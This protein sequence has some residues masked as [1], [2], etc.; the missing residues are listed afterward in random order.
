V[1]ALAH[2]FADRRRTLW[3]LAA[4]VL[5]LRLQTLAVELYNGD[6]ANYAGHALV[7]LDGGVPYVDF[8]EKKPPLIYGLYWASFRALGISLRM[9]HAVTV[10][11][12]FGTCLA[13]YALVGLRL[14]RPYAALAALGY[15]LFSTCFKEADALATNC[16]IVMNLPA[17][18]SSYFLFRGLFSDDERRRKWEISLSGVFVGIA[19][20]FK[21]QAGI[22]LAVSAVWL[23]LERR[24]RLG[25]R[26]A[27]LLALGAGFALPLA[28]VVTI[29]ARLHRLAELY[30]WN[31]AINLG[32]L[33]AGRALGDIVEN[34]LTT[35]LAFVA[36]NLW[37]FALAAL[38]AS[39]RV[40]ERAVGDGAGAL[41][42]YHALWLAATLLPVSMGAR[43]YGHYYIQMYPPLCVLA[44]VV[45]GALLEARARLRPWQ[46]RGF[47]L[48]LIAPAAAFQLA[49]LVRARAGAFEGAWPLHRQVAAAVDELS[50]P[51]DPIFVWGNYSYPYYLARRRPATRYIVC[52]YVLPYWQIH[53]AGRD[54][55]D[56]AEVRPVERR[57]YALLLGDLERRPPRVIVDTSRSP[58]FRNFAPFPLARFPELDALVR[59]DYRRARSIDGVDLYVRRSRFGLTVGGP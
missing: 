18:S 49:A 5:T 36:A 11:W 9:V 19:F 6:E 3:L 32:Y 13:L 29:Y 25:A 33:G 44:A 42:G 10:L 1:D 23:G 46:R 22:G 4:V 15:A 41:V 28:A 54:R 48:A 8:V 59:H 51:G 31:V 38:L 58:H 39:R 2:L 52:E 14:P 35:S 57:N 7:M 56:D 55:F 21:H 30:E 34:A 40:R 26:A 27:D 47:M 53:L 16:E 20:L 12:V 24:R 17:A 50:A 43:F 45:G 37:L